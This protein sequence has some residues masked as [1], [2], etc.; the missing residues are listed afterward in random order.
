MTIW[1]D[2]DS[3][4]RDLRILLLRRQGKEL[5]P[6]KKI[7]LRFVS[8]RPLP[9]IPDELALQVESGPDAADDVILAAAVPGDLIVTRD[10]PLA[11]RVVSK[12]LA[13]I[14]DRGGVFTK[15]AVSERLSL[16]D[17]AAELRLLGLAPVSPKG[18]SRTA[19]DVKRFADALDRTLAGLRKN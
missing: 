12:G 4:P 8:V 3:L 6:G 15:T 5:S 16:R 2:G 1:V 7:T 14:N 11:E 13:C 19:R 18:S 17:A 9:D 10:I